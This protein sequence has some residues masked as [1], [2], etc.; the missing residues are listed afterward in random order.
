[1]VNRFQT[2]TIFA[3]A[4]VAGSVV[5]ATQPIQQ[6]VGAIGASAQVCVLGASTFAVI[7]RVVDHENV[8]VE[9]IFGGLSAYML[10]G[11]VFAWVYLALPG[12]LH[13]QVISPAEP[14]EIPIYYSYVVLTTLGFGDI[15]PVGQLARRVTVFQALV[16]QVFLAVLIA[17]LVT[18]YSGQVRGSAQAEPSANADTAS[19]SD[20]SQ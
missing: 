19:E 17:R 18:Q 9:T 13:D 2:F 8:T 14:G 15:N 4:G 1:M 20:D 16:G 3:L 10:L 6:S 12:Y 7:K 5:V 11:Q